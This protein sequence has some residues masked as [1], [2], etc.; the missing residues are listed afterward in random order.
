M[1]LAITLQHHDFGYV[2]RRGGVELL[3]HLRAGSARASYRRDAIDRA[4]DLFQAAVADGRADAEVGGLGLMILQRSL[5]AA[6]DFGALLHAVPGPDHWSRLRTTTIASIDTAYIRAVESTEEVMADIFRLVDA[7]D[8]R[9]EGLGAAEVAAFMRLRA[10]LVTRW[11]TM[12]INAAMLWLNNRD[13]A[14]A[15]MHAF[16]VIAGEH[17]LGPPPAGTLASR[18]RPPRS[19]RWALAV[20]SRERDREVRT[21][22]T[23]VPLDDRKVAGYRRTGRVVTRL[24][25]EVCDLQNKSITTGHKAGIPV[26]LV[27]SASDDDERLISA[28]VARQE[29]PGG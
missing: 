13:V 25:A 21:V 11:R 3:T 18:L 10:R 26:E 5:L 22:Q 15:T 27:P 29:K 19:G 9:A 23:I 20:T 8:M 24:Y 17:V 16:P 4:F 12:L 14:K 1:H 7:D 28:A 6:E 2:E